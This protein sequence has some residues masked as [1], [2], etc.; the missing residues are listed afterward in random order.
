VNPLLHV[1][2]LS[3][4]F[5]GDAG[6][7]PVLSNINL[8]VQKGEIVGIV[9]ESGSGKSLLLT[10]IPGLLTDP[11]RITSGEVRFQG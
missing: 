2:K 9:G 8:V 1:S 7:L 5:A 4:A 10:A 3:V 11:W 6:L